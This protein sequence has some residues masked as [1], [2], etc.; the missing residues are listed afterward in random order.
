VTELLAKPWE[1][2]NGDAV[3][4]AVTSAKAK[5]W[6]PP[7]P[8]VPGEVLQATRQR[9]AA[10]GES[11]KLDPIKAQAFAK[12]MLIDFNPVK[13]LLRAGLIDA[14]EA[15]SRTP[16]SLYKTATRYE[17]HPLVQQA[18]RDFIH[19]IESDKVVSRERILYGL[20][21][22]ACYH[23][24]GA[25]AGARVAAW[26]KLAK[27]MGMELPDPGEDKGKDAA[28]GGV[29]LIPFAPSIEAWEGAAVGQQAQ[30]KADVRN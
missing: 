16:S 15:T 12:E 5:P 28:P 20:L 10:N 18:L 1:K 14:D 21:E 3:A 30:L 29:M 19:R 2:R 9:A 24:P 6:N 8:S 13:S 27:L 25:S 26:G 7:P 11:V 22:E 23:G 4:D 17:R